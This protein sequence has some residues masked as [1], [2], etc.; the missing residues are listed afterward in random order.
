[1]GLDDMNEDRIYEVRVSGPVPTDVL[2]RLGDVDV[3]TQELRTVLGGR[4]R[5]QAA[6]YGFLHRLRTLGL[7]I[8]EVRQVARG[9][10]GAAGKE[11]A[12]AGRSRPPGNEPE[13]TR[14]YEITVAGQLGGAMRAA[15]RPYCAARSDL[16]TVF[17]TRSS[18]SNGDLVELMM[19]LEANDLVLEGVFCPM[20]S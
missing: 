12:E 18:W 16:C 13:G 9:S 2:F 8:I 17:R 4:F 20:V 15:L 3:L 6:L 10:R 5:D 7:E 1:M 14:R 19:L 11:A